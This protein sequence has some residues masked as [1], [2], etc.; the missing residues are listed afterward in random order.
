[1][2]TANGSGCQLGTGAESALGGDTAPLLR[3]PSGWAPWLWPCAPG[4]A[5]TQGTARPAGEVLLMD[6][7]PSQVARYTHLGFETY[8]LLTLQVQGRTCS[9]NTELPLTLCANLLRFS[10]RYQRVITVFVRKCF[11]ST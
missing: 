8:Q 7:C 10:H 4:K 3:L 9:C 1:M 2:K 5:A 6:G 11:L